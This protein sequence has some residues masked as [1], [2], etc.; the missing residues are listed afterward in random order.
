MCAQRTIPE[1]LREAFVGI[2]EKLTN[3]AP[4]IVEEDLG[5]RLWAWQ[6]VF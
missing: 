3:I 4:M 6:A 2:A 5:E 1:P